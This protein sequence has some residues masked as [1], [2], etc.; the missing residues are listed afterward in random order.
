MVEGAKVVIHFPRDLVNKPI[1]CRLV[2]DFDLEFNVLKAEVNPDEEGLMVLE[3][4][5]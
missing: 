2:K 5:L 4:K 1:I 3:L